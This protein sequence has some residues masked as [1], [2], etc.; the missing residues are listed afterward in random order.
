MNMTTTKIN[1][2]AFIHHT[3]DPK[4]NDLDG[5][6][7]IVRGKK[8]VTVH[9]KSLLG[10]VAEIKRRQEYNKIEAKSDLALLGFDSDYI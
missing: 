9:W 10:F 4:T 6:V 8:R 5:T 7:E 3:F 2:T 1:D